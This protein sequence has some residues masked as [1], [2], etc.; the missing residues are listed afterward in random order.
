M[1]VFTKNGYRPK[2]GDRV[3]AKTGKREV[4]GVVL[5]HPRLRGKPWV[6]QV[7]TGAV[8]CYIVCDDGERRAVYEMELVEE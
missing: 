8:L 6:F 4:E 3:R 7:R 5:E 2:V 1:A